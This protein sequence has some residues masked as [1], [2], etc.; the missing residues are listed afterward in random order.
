MDKG[1]FYGTRD[2]STIIDKTE[3]S[4]VVLKYIKTNKV[5]PDSYI[6][7][8][9]N[10]VPLLWFFTITH[11]RDKKWSSIVKYLIDHHVRFD[12]LPDVSSS[13]IPVLLTD[14]HSMYF[15]YL[16]KKFD[17]EVQKLDHTIIDNKI[18]I[19]LMNADHNRIVALAKKYRSIKNSLKRVS[20]KPENCISTIKKMILRLVTIS[21]CMFKTP[22]K[23]QEPA[24]DMIGE[25]FATVKIMIACGLIPSIELLQLA[26]NYYLIDFVKYFI[27]AM[28]D[29]S[30][31]CNIRIISHDIMSEDPN[32]E[33]LVVCLRHMFNDY[34]YTMIKKILDKYC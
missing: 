10:Y 20:L 18:C 5:H 7:L 34:N 16:L 23:V 11:T 31:I 1:I 17:F 6:K 32:Q 8:G 25:Y 30:Q 29:K 2:L 26:V 19:L 22:E 14:C 33:L 24:L 4:S 28:P 21:T 27:A 3:D 12:K 9:E 15:K 13:E